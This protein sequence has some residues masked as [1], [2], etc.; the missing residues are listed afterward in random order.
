MNALLDALIHSQHVGLAT[1]LF[2]QM[3]ANKQAD[4]VSFNIAL[5]MLLAAGQ[6]N[7][8]EL[9]L[10]DLADCGFAANMVT[11]NELLND[12]VRSSDR[13]GMWGVL[14]EMRAAGLSMNKVTCTILLKA[15]NESSPEEDVQKTFS[16]L[17]DLDEPPDEVLR[18]SAIE[19]CIRMKKRDL[20]SD[21]IARFG[22]DGAGIT[23]PGLSS[24]T[25]GG[26]IKAHGQA[27]DLERT[28]ET[29]REMLSSSVH[30]TSVTTGCM[31]EALVSN[32]AVDDAWSLVHEMLADEV[33]ST[34]INTVI[35]STLLKGFSYAGQ[36]KRCFAVLDEMRSRGIERNT[37]TYNTLLDACAKSGVMDR[38][39]EVFAEMKASC[40]V[41]DMI[42]YASLSA[43]E[44]GDQPELAMEHF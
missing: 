42:T 3:K 37:I 36:L 6:G 21:V 24:A 31:V 28:W 40:V 34:S 17:D 10:Q 13:Q 27:R 35:F 44:K 2:E 25:Y 19:A 23:R 30:P 43:I 14:D 12:R 38:V 11:Y 5:R 8:A 26:M 16:A 33:H 18:S 22:E 32:G 29:W 4:V 7:D 20:L 1:N 15:L 39:P 9:L 41:P